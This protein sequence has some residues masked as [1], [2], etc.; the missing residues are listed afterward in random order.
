MACALRRP[1]RASAGRR[2]GPLG[3]A[4]AHPSARAPHAA[5]VQ[6]VGR[7]IKT[8]S[9]G[10]WPA[11][12]GVPGGTRLDG[13]RAARYGV[14]APG[15]SPPHAAAVQ[16]VRRR[17]K[18][19][20]AGGWPTRYG[21]RGGTRLDGVWPARYGVRARRLAPARR[22]SSACRAAHEDPIGRRMACVVR[23]PRTRRRRPRTPPRQLGWVR[24]ARYGVRAPVGPGPA[25]RR[26]SS[27]WGAS[28]VRPRVSGSRCGGLPGQAARIRPLAWGM[29]GQPARVRQ[30]VWGPAGSGRAY[31]AVQRVGRRMKTRAAGSRPIAVSSVRSFS[32]PGVSSSSGSTWKPRFA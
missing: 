2:T 1:W 29:P 16:P 25:C 20:S 4:S 8:R 10:G 23:R 6:L 30:S 24:P 5:A 13:V 9:A 27:V 11:W 18:T 21:V 17:M 32:R 3:T 7:R 26:G 31:P 28:Q 22:G 12:Y 15:G 19:W 14:R